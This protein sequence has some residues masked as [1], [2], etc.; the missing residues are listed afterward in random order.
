MLYSLIIISRILFQ[1]PV[2]VEDRTHNREY[3]RVRI[4]I[5][6]LVPPCARCKL[7]KADEVDASAALSKKLP[8]P[9]VEHLIQVELGIALRGIEHL[10]EIFC[11]IVAA[12][13][14]IEMYLI[15][16]SR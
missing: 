12:A 6:G 1:S 8:S 15:H 10:L 7:A 13:H 5:R 16:I 9:F 4:G 2:G 14:C 11:G 3:L